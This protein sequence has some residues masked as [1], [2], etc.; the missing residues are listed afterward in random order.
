MIKGAR[1]IILEMAL[2]FLSFMD[3]GTCCA[4]KNVVGIKPLP[5]NS[6]ESKIQYIEVYVPINP[7]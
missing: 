7:H 5:Q 2:T 3:F 1:K 6:T 4:I